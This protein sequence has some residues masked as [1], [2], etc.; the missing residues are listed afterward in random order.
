[1][2]WGIWAEEECGNGSLGCFCFV[3]DDL[4]WG[5]SPCNFVF[6]KLCWGL[7]LEVCVLIDTHAMFITSNSCG[8]SIYLLYRVNRP[9]LY[10]IG[11]GW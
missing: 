4:V 3:L 7:C 1:M 6:R 9:L 5:I 10:N 8:E 2:I 11:L